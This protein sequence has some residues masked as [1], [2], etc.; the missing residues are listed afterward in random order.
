MIIITSAEIFDTDILFEQMG[1]DTKLNETYQTSQLNAIEFLRLQVDTER[2][3]PLPIART[4]QTV[5]RRLRS[6]GGKLVTSVPF[7]SLLTLFILLTLETSLLEIIL[8]MFW[9]E[10]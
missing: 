2:R 7:F 10:M 4:S 9:L 3:L 6:S 5:R 8:L 1:R